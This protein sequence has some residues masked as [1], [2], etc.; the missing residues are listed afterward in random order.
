MEGQTL[1]PN[2]EKKPLKKIGKPLCYEI[3]KHVYGQY[4]AL[5]DL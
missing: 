1:S 3:L 2:Q 4:W 5:L